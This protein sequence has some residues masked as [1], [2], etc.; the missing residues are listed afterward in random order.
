MPFSINAVLHTNAVE[1]IESG[2]DKQLFNLTFSKLHTGSPLLYYEQVGLHKVRVATPVTTV[3]K[4]PINREYA[5]DDT[6]SAF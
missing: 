4:K 3:A 1:N 5:R 6:L 2:I